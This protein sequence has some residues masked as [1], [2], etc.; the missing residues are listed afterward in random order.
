MCPSLRL[1]GGGG[2]PQQ[3]HAG[4]DPGGTRAPRSPGRSDQG[5][6]V[7]GGLAEGGYCHTLFGLVCPL[8]GRHFS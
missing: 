3:E 2:L 6:R 7:C 4:V 5:Q 8:A 1:R